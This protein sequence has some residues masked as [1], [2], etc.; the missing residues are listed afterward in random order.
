MLWQSAWLMCRLEHIEIKDNYDLEDG[1]V[2]PSLIHKFYNALATETNIECWGDGS[3]KR[4]FI[5]AQDLA[6]VCVELL[7]KNE[8]MP[9]RLIVPGQEFSIKEIVEK[10]DLSFLSVY[11]QLGTSYPDIVW[12]KDKPNGQM[13]RKTESQYFDKLFPNFKYTGIDVALKESVKWFTTNYPNCWADWK[14]S[15]RT[16]IR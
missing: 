5:Y 13:R 12:N 14:L 1:H 4:E 10:I 16:L 8:L 6:K 9:Q 7:K 15:S 2:V 3:P 11:S